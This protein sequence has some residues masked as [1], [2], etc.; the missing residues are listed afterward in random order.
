[1]LERR[2]LVGNLGIAGMMMMMMMMAMM[3]IREDLGV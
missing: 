2:N 3:R 1:M